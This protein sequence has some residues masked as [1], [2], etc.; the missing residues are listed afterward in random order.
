MEMPESGVTRVLLVEDELIVRS[1]LQELLESHGYQVYPA[2]DAA[3]ARAIAELDRPDVLVAD[4]Q[5]GGGPTGIDLAHAIQFTY[6]LK[7]LVFLTN[8]PEP[9][10]IGFDSKS[11]PKSAVYLNKARLANS[12]VLV[13]AI[14]ASMSRN[15]PKSMRDDLTEG[16]SLPDLSRS[17]IEVLQ[18]VS[19]GLSNQEIAIKRATGIRAVENLLHRAYE[20][21]GIDVESSSSNVRVNGA[22]A[23]LEAI[24]AKRG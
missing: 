14:E 15:V 24:G 23:Y 6:R 1:L 3:S 10:L 12:N 13:E 8:V 4:I 7:G 19:Q 16:S 21:L 18:L 11:I 17:Q 5:L 20:A 2:S 22:L 9:R